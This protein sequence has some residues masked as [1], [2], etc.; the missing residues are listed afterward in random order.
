MFE[1]RLYTGTC[2]DE[3]TSIIFDVSLLLSGI[4][5]SFPDDIWHPIVTVTL[6][7][8]RYYT[9][10]PRSDRLIWSVIRTDYIRLTLQCCELQ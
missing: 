8:Q 7:T 9:T 4:I 2:F 10:L 3:V 6:Q 5:S 1:D